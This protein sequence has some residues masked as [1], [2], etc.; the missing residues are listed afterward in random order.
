MK[1]RVYAYDLHH[2]IGW[3]PAAE[4]FNSQLNFHNSKTRSL[5][6]IKSTFGECPTLDSTGGAYNTSSNPNRKTITR[7][8]EKSLHFSL[9]TPSSPSAYRS[10]RIALLNSFRRQ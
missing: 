8:I 5:V 9:L 6:S 3:S 2:N 10:C 1:H 4:K 7:L